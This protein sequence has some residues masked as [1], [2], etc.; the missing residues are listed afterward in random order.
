MSF[1]FFPQLIIS[2]I[3]AAINKLAEL[4]NTFMQRAQPML[5]KRLM[6]EIKEISGPIILVTCEDKISVMTADADDSADCT[7]RTSLTAMKE[8]K[9]PNQ[10]TRLIKEGELEIKG[11]IALAQQ[12]STLIS[13]TH[14]DWE[15]HLSYYLGDSLAHKIAHRFKNFGEI[16]AQKN[17][18]F[19]KIIAELLQDEL[20]VAPH[21]SEV[22]NFSSKVSDT[23]AKVD[24][25]AAKVAKMAQQR[26][27][28]HK[29]KGQKE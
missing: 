25:L 19:S 1:F 16:L 8:L 29:A 5:G 7:I 4:D 10:I 17:S 2:S 9:D 23:R 22:H 14:V 28:T 6:V 15:E 20:K 13:E 24:K 3:E 11:D 12:V 27:S 21:S 18:D 26:K